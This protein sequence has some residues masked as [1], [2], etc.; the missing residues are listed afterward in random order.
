M[1]RLD[2]ALAGVQHLAFDSS[3]IIYYMEGQPTYVAVMNSV[4]QRIG[5]GQLAGTTSIVA[6][7]EVLTRP[8]AQGDGQLVESYTGLLLESEHFQ[9]VP[10]GVAT[11]ELAANLRARYGL[12]TPDA[13]QLAAAVTQGCDAFLSN[14]I[15]LR[16]ITEIPVLIVDDLEL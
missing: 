15:R 5:S 3:P 4:F 14:D 12:R 13:L 1:T 6:L 10:I 2:A 8:L 9:T 16:R 11:A 7:V